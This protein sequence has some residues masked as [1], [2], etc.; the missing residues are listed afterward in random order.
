MTAL[1]LIKSVVRIFWL[2][3][4]WKRCSSHHC[5]SRTT[6][7]KNEDAYVHRVHCDPVLR[8]LCCSVEPFPVA[9]WSMA[10]ALGLPFTTLQT[11]FTEPTPGGKGTICQLHWSKQHTAAFRRDRRWF[12]IF[13]NC[14]P[15]WSTHVHP[16]S[17]VCQ[18]KQPVSDFL[19]PFRLLRSSDAFFFFGSDFPIQPLQTFKAWAVEV[20]LPHNFSL[21]NL[22]HS[23]KQSTF[24]CPVLGKQM[25]LPTGTWVTKSCPVAYL[26]V[27][28]PQ[29]KAIFINPRLISHFQLYRLIG[30]LQW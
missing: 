8:L 18:G 21:P 23:R 10:S 20:Q 14:G 12:R 25:C 5:K 3:C 29:L 30:N 19:D 17:L 24:N 27:F 16:V 28:T 11:V 7:T 22:D 15:P 1:E 4:C 2:A 13:W 26:A 9:S 6:G